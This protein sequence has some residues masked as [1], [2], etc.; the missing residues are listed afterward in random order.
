MLLRYIYMSY[1]GVVQTMGRTSAFQFASRDSLLR[2]F[3]LV[4]ISENFQNVPPA[5]LDLLLQQTNLNT[6]NA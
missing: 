6:T 4:E 5:A 2:F 1:R 3:A